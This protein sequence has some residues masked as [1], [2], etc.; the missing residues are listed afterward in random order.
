MPANGDVINT[1]DSEEALEEKEFIETNLTSEY[2]VDILK[3]M[4]KREDNFQPKWN[5]MTKQVRKLFNF[6]Y[7]NYQRLC[8]TC[9]ILIYF[10]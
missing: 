7:R 1:E 6:F 8:K 9:K 3:N 5:Y 4:I 2:A 10:F